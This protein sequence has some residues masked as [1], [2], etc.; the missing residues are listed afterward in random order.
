M[1][2]ELTYF[3]G[4]QVKQTDK[5]I[6]INQAKY[7][8]NL[9]KRFGLENAAHARTPMAINTKLGIDPSG[10]L[11]DITLYRSIIGCLL[12]LTASCLDISFS[13][14]VCAKFQANPKMLHLTVVKRIIK[15][16]SGTS[17]FGLFYIKE[18]NVSLAGYSDV[19]W[20]GNAD[21]RKST[22][23]GCFYVGTNLVAWMS[24]KQN[25]VSLS[26]AEAEYITARSCC[27]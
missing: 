12:Y 27:T 21:D 2:G 1:V 15:Y 3:L 10:Q 4:L 19:D 16:V 18:S 26:T 14:G 20:V 5:G 6:Y 9:V 24:K 13:V 25:F 23:G 22:I 17:D 8:R 11:V 7:A